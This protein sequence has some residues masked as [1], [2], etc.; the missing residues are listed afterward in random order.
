MVSGGTPLRSKPEYYEN[1]VIPWLKTGDIKKNFIY[2]VDEY[3]TQTGLENSSAKLIPQ[4]SVI[5]AMYGD[6]NTAGNVA[7]NKIQL[8]TNQACCNLIVDTQKAHYLY[9]FYYLKGS[10]NNLVGLKLGGSQ[11]NLN[12]RTIKNF[13]I[14]LPPLETQKKIAAVLSAYD[15]LIENNKRQIAL[16]ENMAEEIYREWF[17]RFRFPGWQRTQFEKGIPKNWKI[18]KLNQLIELLYGKALKLED[19]KGGEYPV[20]GSSGIVGFHD[21]AIVNKPGLIVGRKGN[22]GSIFL[23][24]KPFYPIDTVYHVRSSLSNY[25]LFYLLKSMN[26]INNDAAVPGLNRNQAYSNNVLEPELSLIEKFVS[27][28]TPIFEQKKQLQILMANLERQKQSLLPRLISGKLSVEELDIAFPP[29]MQ[30][31][32]EK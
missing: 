22:V 30:E 20:Y 31:T 32:V 17:V 25:Y 7:V 19:R 27:L 28:V 10:Y 5:V 2:E 6:G 13:P 24:D 12:A 8:T 16:L 14:R 1:G 18:K 3:I 11:Q 29:S 23:S 15:D 21:Q 9:V 4:N 26:F